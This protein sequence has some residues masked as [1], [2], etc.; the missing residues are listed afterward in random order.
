MYLTKLLTDWAELEPK[1]L[2]V[3]KKVSIFADPPVKVDIFHYKFPIEIDLRSDSL[4]GVN[5]YFIQGAVQAAI[6]ARKGWYWELCSYEP[7]EYC[8]VESATWY[9]AFVLTPD[10]GFCCRSESPVYSLLEAYLEAIRTGGDAPTPTLT[11][12]V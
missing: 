4:T 5:L 1:V 11:G 3:T 7:I 6:D 8:G 10:N 2:A 12:T 9:E